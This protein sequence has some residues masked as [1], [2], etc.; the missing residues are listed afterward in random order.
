[1]SDENNINT[2]NEEVQFPE[3]PYLTRD[4]AI[5]LFNLEKKFLKSYVRHKDSMP[6][7]DWLKM[8]IK[9]ELP[10]YK[11]RSHRRDVFRYNNHNSS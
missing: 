7:I 6:V 3:N 11:R 9:T 4:E 2:H 1:M 5:N 8:E 10:D